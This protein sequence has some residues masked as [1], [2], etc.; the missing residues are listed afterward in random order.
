MLEIDQHDFGA[1]EP[2]KFNFENE[3]PKIVDV[4]ADSTGRDASNRQMLDGI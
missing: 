1:A 3:K 4:K 2:V